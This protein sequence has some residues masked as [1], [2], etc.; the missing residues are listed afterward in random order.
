M[1]IRNGGHATADDV[2]IYINTK[3]QIENAVGQIGVI[4][5]KIEEQRLFEEYVSFSS[6]ITYFYANLRHLHCGMMY[7]LCLI[8]S[9]QKNDKSQEDYIL[10]TYRNGQAQERKQSCFLPFVFGIGLGV[11]SIVAI[12]LLYRKK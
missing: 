5:G 10:I 3:G 11:C 7:R 8:V 6:N 2:D 1:T 4:K 12:I 9:E